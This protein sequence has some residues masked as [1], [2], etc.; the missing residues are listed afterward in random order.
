MKNLVLWI[1]TLSFLVFLTSCSADD[2][3]KHYNESGTVLNKGLTKPENN[4][5]EYDSIGILQNDILEA[6]L[7]GNHNHQ[8]IEEIA[9][10]VQSLIYDYSNIELMSLNIDEITNI[11]DSPENTLNAV[12]LGSHLSNKA[13]TSLTDFISSLLYLLRDEYENKYEFIVLYESSILEDSLLNNEDKRVI[14]TTTTILRHSLYYDDNRKD[15]DWET[16][17]GHITATVSGAL[18]NQLVAVNM[19]LVTG[20]SIK[21]LYTD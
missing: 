8:S 18:E 11:I 9:E 13:K 2:L 20:I 3:T 14:L 21:I 1:I 10:E 5:N 4:A 7:S 15:K 16:S 6:Y 12:I 17:V 19:F